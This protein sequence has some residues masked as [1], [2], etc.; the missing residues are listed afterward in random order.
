MCLGNI[1]Q[2]CPS[3]KEAA[4][5]L[6]RLLESELGYTEGKVDPIALRLLIQAKW[7]QVATLAHVIHGNV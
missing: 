4:V 1:Q 7:S 3:A 5:Q 2:T 6:A